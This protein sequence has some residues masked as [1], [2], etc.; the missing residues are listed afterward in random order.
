MIVRPPLNWQVERGRLSDALIE[1]RD[2]V[3]TI[4]DAAGLETTTSARSLLPWLEQSAPE[5]RP[6]VVSESSVYLA[7]RTR[8]TKLILSR[9]DG[10]E[11]LYDLEA[12]P[13]ETVNIATDRPDEVDRLK[14]LLARWR[15][16]LQR[17]APTLDSLD[18]KTTEGLRAIGYLD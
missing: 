16:D 10:A 14:S 17:T 12:D 7:A 1:S 8:T 6:F 5:E 9:D 18:D 2:V 4:E 3:A 11:V 13:F 15:G